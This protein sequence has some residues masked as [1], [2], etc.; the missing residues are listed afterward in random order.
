MSEFDGPSKKEDRTYNTRPPPPEGF[1]VEIY[2]AWCKTNESKHIPSN[3]LEAATW[4]INHQEPRRPHEQPE[5][6]HDRQGNQ[7]W[8]DP[9]IN[10]LVVCWRTFLG[11]MSEPEKAFIIDAIENHNTPW[12]GDDI[13]FYKL[14]IEQQKIMD[15]DPEK[16]KSHALKSVARA[17]KKIGERS[18]A[19]K[20]DTP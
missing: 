14:V 3:Y 5:A 20:G 1:L 18:G 11:V 16:Y 17:L 15:Q 12:R 9:Y 6:S 10:R 13:K 7:H 19:M 2:K 4:W 8:S